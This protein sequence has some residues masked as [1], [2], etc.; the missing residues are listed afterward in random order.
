MKKMV[1]LM[2]A[3]MA[4]VGCS[5]EPEEP[6]IADLTYGTEGWD[7]CASKIMSRMESADTIENDSIELQ[8]EGIKQNGNQVT[9]LVVYQSN[10][11]AI[12]G[13]ESTYKYTC[14]F[15][16]GE[17]VETDLSSATSAR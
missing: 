4:L 2:I 11:D 17:V 7:R 9:G 10:L 15:E 8:V 1:A 6:E 12:F 16:D 13:D 3:G 5:P 14:T